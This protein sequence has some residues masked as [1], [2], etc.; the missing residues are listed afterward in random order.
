MG[1]YGGLLLYN[2][3]AY[4]TLACLPKANGATWGVASQKCYAETNM[5]GHDTNSKY[6][7]CMLGED[8]YS[9][10]ATEGDMLTVTFKSSQP[11]VTIRGI[12][13]THQN[14]FQFR[15]AKQNLSLWNCYCLRSVFCR[16]QTFV[17]TGDTCARC[18]ELSD[19]RSR[20]YQFCIKHCILYNPDVF[21]IIVVF[22]IIILSPPY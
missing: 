11:I 7:T 5:T 15:N 19:P 2:I 4:M 17:T 20:S 8:S 12:N 3:L 13:Y 18:Y 16:R 9:A 21:D 10:Y 22:D 14:A 1:V 6:T